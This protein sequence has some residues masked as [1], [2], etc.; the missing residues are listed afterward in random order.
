MIGWIR[1]KIRKSKEW[2]ASHE[3]S[4]AGFDE[5][6]SEGVT[7]F[8]KEVLSELQ[9][10]PGLLSLELVNGQSE[11]YYK[12]KLANSAKEFFIYKDEA[13]LNGIVFE[14]WASDSRQD[15]ISMFLS[16]ARDEEI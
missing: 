6:N 9:D 13:E 7:N 2:R 15:L 11:N 16:G 14:R 5:V 1:N 8:Q 3:A 12:G 10:N 4:W